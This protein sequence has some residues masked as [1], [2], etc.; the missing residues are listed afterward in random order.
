MREREEMSD[1]D[2]DRVDSLTS[3]KGHTPRA[4]WSTW[5]A[6]GSHSPP[7]PPPPPPLLRTQTV[8]IQRMTREKRMIWEL[9]ISAVNA[10]AEGLG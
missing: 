5:H 2:R 10:V 9:S 3:M 7:P 6:C 1:C 4:F 8:E